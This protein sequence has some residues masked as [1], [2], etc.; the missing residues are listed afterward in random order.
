MINDAQVMPK[1]PG[2]DIKLKMLGDDAQV[3]LPKTHLE[4]DDGS[5]QSVDLRKNRVSPMWEL[6]LW[7]K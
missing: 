4:R 3:M 2:D 6:Y 7:I 1:R 5:M